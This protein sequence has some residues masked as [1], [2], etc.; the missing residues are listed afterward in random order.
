MSSIN[1]LRTNEPAIPTLPE[2]APAVADAPVRT[3]G[4]QLDRFDAMLVKLRAQHDPM[5]KGR[6]IDRLG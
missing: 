5:G 3:V 1:P 2:R 6:V 4:E